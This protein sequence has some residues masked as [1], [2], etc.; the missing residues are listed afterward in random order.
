MCKCTPEV[1]TPFCGKGDCTWPHKKKPGT[2]ESSAWSHGYNKGFEKGHAAGR[3]EEMERSAK[4]VEA[5]V[6][7]DCY[8]TQHVQPVSNDHPINKFRT[9]LK[10]Y[11][12]GGKTKKNCPEDCDDDVCYLDTPPAQEGDE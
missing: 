8:L 6:S 11:R 3:A 2:R 1:R 10:Q 12:D 4:L 5:T 9:A 7:L